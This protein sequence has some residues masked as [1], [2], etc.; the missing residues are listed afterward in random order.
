MSRETFHASLADQEK[1]FWK[2]MAEKFGKLKYEGE[3]APKGVIVQDY[4]PHR[5]KK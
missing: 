2:A 3:Q 1:Q 5:V 4:Q